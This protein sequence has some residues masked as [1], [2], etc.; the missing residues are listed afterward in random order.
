MLGLPAVVTTALQ[1]L[2]LGEQ[3]WLRGRFRRRVPGLQRSGTT[4]ALDFL[5]ELNLAYRGEP[6]DRG[7]IE[8][9][10]CETFLADLRGSYAKKDWALRCLVLLDNI[11]NPLGGEVL[12]LLLEARDPNTPDPLC[13]LGT[14]GSYPAELE[15]HRFGWPHAGDDHPGRW[16]DTY[17]FEPQQVADGLRVGQLRDLTRREVEH[18]APA[19]LERTDGRA[20]RKGVPWLGWVVH[21]L[22]RGQPEGTA[23]VLAAPPTYDPDK[24]WAERLREI[25]EPAGPF[26]TDLLER[27]L[28]LEPV[29]DLPRALRRAAVAP[30]LGGVPDPDGLHTPELEAAFQ[31]FCREPLHTLT[32]TRGHGYR[33]PAVT[34]HPLLRRLLLLTLSPDPD[35][36][37][38][39]VPGPTARPHRSTA[40]PRSTTACAPSPRSAPARPP[41]RSRA[42]I[43]PWRPATSTRSTSTAPPRRGVPPVPTAPRARARLGAQRRDRALEPLR[44]PGPAPP[45]RRDRPPPAHHHPPARGKLAGP[46]PPED[47]ATD[48]VGDPYRDPLGDPH[49]SLYSEINARFHTLADAHTGQEAWAGPVATKADQY[50]EE[51]WL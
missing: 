20:P 16:Q 6:E 42:A 28:P 51:P 45:G 4:S 43:C 14:A 29:D 39:P 49:A 9:L 2:L 26:A 24:L 12:G 34:P 10:A 23:R 30:D 41:R 46:E 48:L 7:P 13:L 40:R 1:L 3:H 21:E 17:A 35:T 25:F 22:T 33:R 47:P 11:D 27:L 8:I 32:S 37:W 50:A 31:A 15:P 36:E 5:I 44:V 18:Q 38:P 19:V